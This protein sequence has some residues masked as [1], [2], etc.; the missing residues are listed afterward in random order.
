ML[1]LPK[2]GQVSIPG[3]PQDDVG[4]PADRRLSHP[5]HPGP[6]HHIHD[7]SNVPRTPLNSEPPL[8]DKCHVRRQHHLA[9][10]HHH[11]VLRSIPPL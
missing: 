3:M 4:A 9:H 7:R 2:E 8:P 11:R 6:V 10:L 5:Q 1:L